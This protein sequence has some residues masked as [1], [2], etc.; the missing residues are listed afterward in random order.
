MKTAIKARTGAV[1]GWQVRPKAHHLPYLTLT[2]HYLHIVKSFSFL[3]T[4]TI[5]S[6]EASQSGEQYAMERDITPRMEAATGQ[7]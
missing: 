2:L 7:Q 5:R 6:R 4:I 3:S 1:A